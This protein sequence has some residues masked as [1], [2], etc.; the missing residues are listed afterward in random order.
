MKP[1]E[2]VRLSRERCRAKYSLEERTSHP[3]LRLQGAE[4]AMRREAFLDQIGGFAP[5]LDHGTLLPDGSRYCLLISDSSGFV[6]EAYLPHGNERELGNLGIGA[7]GLWDER[8]AGTNGIGMALQTGQVFSVAGDE[9]YHR[10]FRVFVCTSAP[11]RDAQANVI[12]SV[13][14][15]GSAKRRGDEVAWCEKILTMVSR[16]FQTR[17]FRNFHEGRMTARLFSMAPGRAGQFESIAACDESGRIVAH[18][19]LSTHAAVPAE[20]LDLVGEHLSSLPHLTATVRGP[21]QELPRRRVLRGAAG[22]DTALPR[23]FPGDELARIAGQGGGMDRIV[24]RARKLLAHRVPILV[25]GEPAIGKAG[26]VTDVLNDLQLSSPMAIRIDCAQVPSDDV[27]DEALKQTGYLSEYPI[28]DVVPSLTLLNVNR[29]D[30]ARK[31][32]LDAFLRSIAP[33]GG[34][35]VAARPLLIFTADRPWRD[36]CEDGGLSQS[37]LY[38]MGQA[39]LDIPP[40][41]ERDLAVVLRDLVQSEFPAQ[42]KI[43]PLAWDAMLAHDWPG[44][45]YEVRAAIREALICGN[46]VCINLPDL[47]P[48]IAQQAPKAS[49]KDQRQLLCEALDSTGWNVTQAAK[50]LGKSRATVNR[51]ILE[52]GL[53]R[54]E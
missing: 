37:M 5:E 19:P 13:T 52:Q 1:A 50:L 49:A 35:E 18:L 25:C 9:H 22:A 31:L 54:P 4:L 7:G 17:L 27:F 23:R 30:D 14:L 12:G 46:G 29:L 34:A 42:T 44:N 33:A 2:M 53:S 11:L 16:R 10:C 15:V 3:V 26:L 39:V 45:L 51:W 28:E 41:R 47:P 36:L 48:R 40:L 6:V 8:T 20:H 43:S 32:R 38:Q 21:A 24:E